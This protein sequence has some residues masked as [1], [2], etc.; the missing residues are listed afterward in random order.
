MMP[1]RLLTACRG[2]APAHSLAHV[3]GYKVG[4]GLQAQLAGVYTEVVAL[5]VSPAL[6]G[7]VIVI[8]GAT[9]LALADILLSLFGA[10]VAP[11]GYLGHT[12]VHAGCDKHVDHVGHVAQHVVGRASHEYTAT[13]GSRLADGIALE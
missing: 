9:A 6:A 2:L 13:L 5:A 1:M 3:F 11:P 12:A 7:I 8:R 4:G 10:Q